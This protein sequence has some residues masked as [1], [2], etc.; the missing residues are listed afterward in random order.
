MTPKAVLI[1]AQGQEVRF[2]VYLST[3]RQQAQG[4]LVMGVVA[5][6]E[7]PVLWPAW[8]SFVGISRK[9]ELEDQGPEFR[10]QNT[11]ER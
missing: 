3:S 8:L 7:E 4:D 10:R 9:S 6:S 11:K 1:Q 2:E 5:W